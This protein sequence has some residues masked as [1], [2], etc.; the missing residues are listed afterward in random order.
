MSGRNTIRVLSNG[1]LYAAGHDTQ[2]DDDRIPTFNM[3]EGATDIYTV[4]WS[5]WTFGNAVT[6]AT[7]T[8]TGGAITNASVTGARASMT[9]SGLTEGQGA[10]IKCTAV[11]T[12][13]VGVCKFRIMSPVGLIGIA[14]IGV[15]SSGYFIEAEEGP[16]EP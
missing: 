14:S 13:R 12:G 1:R 4:D 11:S 15:G 7:W 2:L 3:Q 6:S 16:L 8:A 10:E 9:F 5:G